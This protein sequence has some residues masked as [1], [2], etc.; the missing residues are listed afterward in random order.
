M[1]AKPPMSN[2][3]HV[4]SLD[5]L[6]NTAANTGPSH[7]VTLVNKDMTVATPANIKPTNHLRLTMNDIAAPKSGLIIPD[8]KHIEDLLAFTSKWTQDAPLLI[9]CLAG[10]SRSTAATFITLCSLNPQTDEIEIAKALRTASP[11]AHPNRLLVSHGDKLLG[12]NGLMIKAI[13]DMEPAIVA[14]EGT[15]FSM[16]AKIP[17]R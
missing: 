10:I 6:E 3:I 2:N 8:Q 15:P 11:T 5:A 17:F 12:R 1:I 4:C 14:S 16:P 9:H 7:L 13:E